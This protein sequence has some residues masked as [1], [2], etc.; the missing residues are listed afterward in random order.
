MTQ[1]PQDDTNDLPDLSDE[2]EVGLPNPDRSA[3]GKM[4]PLDDDELAVAA[5]RER[6]EAGVDDYVPD[7]VPDATDPLPEGTSDEADLV[8]RG[9]V[10][11]DVAVNGDGEPV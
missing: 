8:Q 6:V 7:D 1:T 9:I 2:S 3:H 5:A 11:S 10:E 4:P